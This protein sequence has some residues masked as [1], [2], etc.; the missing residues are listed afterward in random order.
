[1]SESSPLVNARFI[2]FKRSGKFY[3]DGR[4]VVPREVF[5]PF[6]GHGD[7]TPQTNTARRLLQANGNHM[8]GL[9][10]T[11]SEFHIVVLLDEDVDFGWPIII[12]PQED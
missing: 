2:Y 5:T 8:P 7:G 3:S 4:G 1:M 6:L 10:T 12:F 9:S 11:G